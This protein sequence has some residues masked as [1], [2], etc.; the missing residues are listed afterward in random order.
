[1]KRNIY[2]VLRFMSK[3]GRYPKGFPIDDLRKRFDRD[4]VDELLYYDYIEK[5]DKNVRITVRGR[6]ALQAHV[7]T[8]ANLWAAIVAAIIALVALFLK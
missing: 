6:E 3:S 5:L 1:M 4:I 7:L 2:S 8:A